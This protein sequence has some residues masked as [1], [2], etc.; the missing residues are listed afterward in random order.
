VRDDLDFETEAIEATH[1]FKTPDGDIIGASKD[2][3][4]W[5]LFS[6]YDADVATFDEGAISNE[7]ALQRLAEELAEIRQNKWSDA[8]DVLLDFPDSPVWGDEKLTDFQNVVSAYRLIDYVRQ[9]KKPT[10]TQASQ[11]GAGS[12]LPVGFDADTIDYSAFIEALDIPML[13][14]GTYQS[15]TTMLDKILKGELDPRI[16]Q[17]KDH[18]DFFNKA[19]FDLVRR[20]KVK[21]DAIIKRDFGSI[22]E[23]PVDLIQDATGST[24]GIVVPQDM[25]DTIEDTFNADLELIDADDALS[26]DDRS[27][28]VDAAFTKRY[29]AMDAAEK[30]VAASIRRRRDEALNEL[31]KDSPELVAHIVQLRKLTD[32]LSKKVT[33]LYGFPPELKAKF[34]N[35]LGIYLTRSYRMFDEIGYG[36]K[37]LADPNYEPVRNAAIQ[38]FEQQF[39]RNETQ[40]R[41]LGPDGLTRTEAEAE[42]RKEMTRK[43][44][45]GRS[46]GQLAMEEFV[47]S[48]DQT[49]P[50]YTASGLSQSLKPLLDNVKLKRDL[51]K[52]I[53]DLLG[54]KGAEGGA[55]NLLRS[56]V[57][58]GTM[59]ANQTFLNHVRT[60]GRDSGWL[61]SA[62]DIAEKRKTD[63]DTYGSYKPIRDTAAPAFDPL[64][65]LYGP[66]ELVR[67]LQI[68]FATDSS[69]SHQSEARNVVQKSV[70]LVAKLSGAAMAVKTLGSIGFYIRN[71]ASNVLFFAPSQGFLN[72]KSMAASAG[73]EIWTNALADPARIDAYRSKLFLLG[74]IG[75]DINT[76]IMESL[77]RGGAKSAA[78]I[79]TQLD[80]L[81]ETAKKGAKPLTWL[82]DRAK[83]LSSSVDAF[84][85]IAYFE[86][87]LGVLRR[88]R[89]ADS[90]R[91]ATASDAELERLAAQ[92]VLATAQSVSQAPPVIR[93]FTKSG[94]G[95][96]FAPFIRFK[97][98]VPRIVINTYRTAFAEISSGNPVLRTRGIQRAAGMS[99]MLGGISAITPMI[100][101]FLAGIGEDED[102]ALRAGLPE[103]LRNHTFF[104]FR[105]DNGQLQ[106]WDFTFL[107]PYAILADPVLRSMEHLLRGEPA[108]AAAKFVQTALFDQYLDDQI[109]SSAIQN[110]R[111]NNN[112]TTGRPIYERHL[113]GVGKTAIK[114]MAFVFK[115][116]YQPSVMKRALDSYRAMGADYTEFDN[117]PIGI[118][119]REVY[120]VKRHNIELDKS[121]RRYLSDMRETY[122]RVSQRKSNPLL[123]NRAISTEEIK[124]IIQAEI[125]DK[126]RLN[127]DLYRKL[128]GFEKLGMTPKQLYQVST[129]AGVGK[130]RATLLFN[131]L[132][133]RPVLGPEMIKKLMDPE[134]PQGPERLR[135]AAEVLRATPRYILLDP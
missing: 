19:T 126:V 115:E 58:V 51:P 104:Y 121:L 24:K 40:R 78:D 127:E 83:I 29:A 102:E 79:E 75:D 41:M 21:M 82:A 13:E 12:Q 132:M 86:N 130:S 120:P 42:A 5:E 106:S 85:K 39:I 7:D 37:V 118:L 119:L 111:D 91:L 110:L 128:R 116:A 27:A 76:N 52:P 32:E 68:A 74:V 131:Q 8:Y 59:A 61:I 17:L 18:R 70:G 20:Y 107:N 49:G 10:R 14:V 33:S 69:A 92:K 100:A 54:E 25:V 23:A 129:G 80:E 96:L 35:Q 103:Y 44:L 34:D 50:S 2:D 64:G 65:D 94:L 1:L 113:D 60:V 67:A 124:G 77:L 22:E 73:S 125:D 134:N 135:A 63:Y 3:G 30:T 62:K 81:I 123:S 98:E 16:K 90:G 109:L 57:T 97:A 84:Y 72:L 4:N 122:N 53:R 43:S 95:L 71:V 55:D 93:E 56:L 88:A 101:A 48:Y 89:D 36:D 45:G 47:R 15:P 114:S 9:L 26:P 6:L 46:Y 38:F 31:A 108:E 11:F 66:A 105:R 112:P 28:A 117:S 99:F 133:D 87:E